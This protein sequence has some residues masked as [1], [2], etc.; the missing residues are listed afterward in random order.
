MIASHVSHH[1]PGTSPIEIQSDSLSHQLI[2]E[3]FMELSILYPE[4]PDTEPMDSP[5]FATNDVDKE[6]DDNK[7]PA[8]TP[9]MDGQVKLVSSI[10]AKLQQDFEVLKTWKDYLDNTRAII[11]K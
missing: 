5:C 9:K 6:M 11:D 7:P 1:S 8:I 3:A 4:S 2:P 10:L